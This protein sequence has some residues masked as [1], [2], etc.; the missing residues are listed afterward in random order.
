MNPNSSH[1]LKL[2]IITNS[3]KLCIYSFIIL[4]N[5]TQHLIE[6]IHV[7]DVHQFSLMNVLKGI[8][9]ISVSL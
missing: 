3:W 1:M 5:V 7:G 6:I 9:N 2:L 8:S 4:E